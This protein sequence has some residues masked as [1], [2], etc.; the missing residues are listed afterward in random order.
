GCLAL[1]GRVVEHCANSGTVPNGL[2]S[3]CAFLGRFQTA[4][5]LSNGAPISS[6][7][8]EDLADHSC[9]FPHP[10]KARLSSPFLFR[11]IAI[12]VRSSTQHADFSNLC[13]MP[14]ASPTAL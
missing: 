13:A 9:L 2:A 11:H 10:L 8:F 7:P 12:A 14:L 3:S 5:N 1:V 4:T 6:D